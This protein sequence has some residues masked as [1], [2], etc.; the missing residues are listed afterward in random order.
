MDGIQPVKEISAEL[1]GSNS[2]EQL[3]T[4]PRNDAHLSE[5]LGSKAVSLGRP[6]L[7]KEH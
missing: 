7:K 2:V 3:V 1:P 6:A 4:G 5:P